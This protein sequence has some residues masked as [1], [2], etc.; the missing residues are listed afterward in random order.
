MTEQAEN[1]IRP[2]V[3]ASRLS[4][5]EI[6]E[7]VHTTNLIRV[8]EGDEL[9]RS[10]ADRD[11]W[12]WRCKTCGAGGDAVSQAD[13]ALDE[14]SVH[15]AV[16]A[17]L[18]GE[19]GE[20]APDDEPDASRAEAPIEQQILDFLHGWISQPLEAGDDPRDGGWSISLDALADGGDVTTFADLLVH[21][22]AHRAPP[23][24]FASEGA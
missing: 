6:S 8:E 23:Q 12:A 22:A 10:V 24:G 3:G 21:L 20:E 4:V 5:E 16:E 15:L 19:F 13:E 1:T 14:A 2:G 18:Y 17:A 7:N 9:A 11:G